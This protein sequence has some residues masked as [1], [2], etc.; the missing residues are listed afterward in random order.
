MTFLDGTKVGFR[1]C[2]WSL[3]Q[4]RPLPERIPENPLFNA[5]QRGFV[6]AIDSAHILAEGFGCGPAEQPKAESEALS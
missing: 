6:A 5:F 3:E 2:A 4:G 1:F